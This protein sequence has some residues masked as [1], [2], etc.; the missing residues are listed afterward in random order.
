M[1]MHVERQPQSLR[2]SFGI[3]KI[4]F[5]FVGNVQFEKVFGGA[6]I[7]RQHS[8]PECIEKAPPPRYAPAS[9]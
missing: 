2:L 8:R 9:N 1:E 7:K 3:D 4:G 6:R 5:R